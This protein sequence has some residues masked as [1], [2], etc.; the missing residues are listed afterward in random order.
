MMDIG[1]TVLAPCKGCKDRWLNPDTLE[2][3]HSSCGKYKEYKDKLEQNRQCYA[4]E[5]AARKCRSDSLDKWSSHKNVIKN[6]KV[7]K[8]KYK[9]L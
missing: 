6:E 9:T 1:K 3:C 7:K 5:L 2:R 4:D 8:R